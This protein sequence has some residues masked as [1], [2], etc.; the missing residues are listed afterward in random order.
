MKNKK[1]V[2]VLAATTLSL[3]V[4]FMAFVS[5]PLIDSYKVIKV[6]GKITYVKSGVNLATGDNFKSSEK[7]TFDTDDSRAAVISKLK[8]RFVLTPSAKGGKA[9]NL[10]P[11]MSNVSTRG[12]AMINAMDLKNHFS[13]NYLL[14]DEL[15]LKV[16]SDSYPMNNNNFFYLQYE[17]NGEVIPKKLKHTGD[18][19]EFTASDIFTVDGKQLPIPLKTDMSIYYRDNINKVSKKISS[20]TLVVPNTEN[21]KQ[22]LGIIVSE[23]KDDSKENSTKEITSYLYEFYGKPQSANVDYWLEKEMG[24]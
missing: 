10:L 2:G 12:G 16:N 15:E 8:G 14:L 3:G 7:L 19:L 1:F 11:A 18:V 13:E 5:S 22:E 21:L 4:V 9:A 24:F 17:L 23:L 20:F 6:D